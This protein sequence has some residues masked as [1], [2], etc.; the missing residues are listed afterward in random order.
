ME[1]SPT[2]FTNTT[3]EMYV[4]SYWFVFEDDGLYMINQKGLTPQSHFEA[5]KSYRLTLQVYP[6]NSV[7]IIGVENVLVNDAVP[8]AYGGTG[9]IN[10]SIC[11]HI[12]FDVPGDY[13]EPEQP[14]T[15]T[16]TYHKYNT[17]KSFGS[18]H[19]YVCDYCG[20]ESIFKQEH[21]ID[22]Y[23]IKKPG[24]GT[25]VCDICGEKTNEI[26]INHTAIKGYDYDE[27]QHWVKEC[28]MCDISTNDS[29]IRKQEHTLD[30]N[31]AKLQSL[32]LSLT[33]RV[34]N[35]LNIF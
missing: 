22:C 15:E 6:K 10:S 35:K 13:I 12:L 24:T 21:V 4:V 18:Y 8:A 27:N 19:A 31:G 1:F 3:S 5:G 28:L 17:I 34:L 20:E 16:C 9:E 25:L 7:N 30:I 23:N 26:M 11:V 14:T 32:K 29:L 33:L 2:T